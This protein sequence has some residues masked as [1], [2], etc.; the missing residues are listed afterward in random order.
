MA[1]RSSSPY[2][3]RAA[4]ALFAFAV[5]GLPLPVAACD[6]H[7]DRG[8]DAASDASDSSDGVPTGL[9]W[10]T[11]C[12]DPVCGGHSER[13]GIA[14]CIDQR[15]GDPCVTPDETC[16]PINDCN[17]LL[18]CTDTDPTGGPGG[19]PI[20]RRDAKRDIAYLDEAAV[21]RLAREVLAI[22]LTTWLYRL[23]PDGRPPHLGFIIED[24]EAQGGSPAIDPRGDRVDLYGYASLA[25]AGLQA[26]ARQLEAMRAE[27]DATRTELEAL[28][29]ELEA[30]RDELEAMQVE[31][32]Q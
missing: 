26:Q 14:L 4:R 5:A 7:D 27:S 18:L 22:P 13:P 15:A 29:A 19:C 23:E 24:L 21:E 3:V 2:L 31:L 9:Q 30:V 1:A 8:S 6:G 10:Y 17:A 11:T 20:S 32:A 16:D 28:R 25:I 12:G